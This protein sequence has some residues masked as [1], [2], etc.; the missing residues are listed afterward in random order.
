[1]RHSLEIVRKAIQ[2]ILDKVKFATEHDLP[3]LSLITT[4]FKWVNDVKAPVSDLSSSI[5]P[6]QN[7][8]LGKWTGDAASIYNIKATQQKNAVDDTVIKAEFISQWLFKI[9]K[10]NVDYAAELAKVV[11]K[12]AGLLTQAAVDAGSIIDLPLVMEK[13]STS[14]GTLVEDSLNILITIG[15][16]FID[17]LGDVRDL[18]AQQDDHS[19]LPMGKWPEAVTI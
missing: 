8:N 1:V 5:L 7:P 12:L 10:S 11:T 17:T 18:A 19:K 6:P 15:Q 4:S 9:A 13:L 16:R 2:S 3:V 14:V